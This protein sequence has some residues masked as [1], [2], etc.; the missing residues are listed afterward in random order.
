MR[1]IRLLI[2]NLVLLGA[3]A[4][5]QTPP[6]SAKEVEAIAE[7][8]GKG[9]KPKSSTISTWRQLI[10]GDNYAAFQIRAD[11]DLYQFVLSRDQLTKSIDALK[12]Y[13]AVFRQAKL[14]G[15]EAVGW[16][17]RTEV[18]LKRL[19]DEAL[20]ERFILNVERRKGRHATLSLTFES[21]LLTFLGPDSPAGRA[22][23]GITIQQSQ[24]VQL[25]EHLE[26]IARATAQSRLTPRSS[27]ALTASRQA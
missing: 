8:W 27:G 25:Q 20:D 19:G 23:K 24:A 26:E 12:N 9:S 22:Y 10:Q 21:W 6:S 5:A 11:L 17:Y 4:S 1:S 13:Q 15:D 14:D 7:L 16:L 3:A 18:R 2:L